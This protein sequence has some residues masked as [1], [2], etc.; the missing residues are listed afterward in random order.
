MVPKV[1]A[2]FNRSRTGVSRRAWSMRTAQMM[3][4]A[5]MYRVSAANAANT[6]ESTRAGVPLL[7]SP[8]HGL[9]ARSPVAS[10]HALGVVLAA[11]GLADAPK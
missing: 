5:P 3:S 10:T 4:A 9:R 2:C 11:A 8:G 6:A 7:A 1:R